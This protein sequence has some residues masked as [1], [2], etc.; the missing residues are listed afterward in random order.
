MLPIR[1]KF[2][3][4]I[5]CILSGL[6]KIAGKTFKSHEKLQE[7]RSNRQYFPQVPIRQKIEKNR[8]V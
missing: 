6:T 4:G 2:R 3:H 7:I 8:V 1:R 5:P